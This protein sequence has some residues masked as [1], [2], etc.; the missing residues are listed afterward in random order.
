LS[1][2]NEDLKKTPSKKNKYC[3]KTWRKRRDIK[4]VLGRNWQRKRTY[5]RLA[6][7]TKKKRSMTE[8]Y[9]I[10]TWIEYS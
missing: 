5:Y 2:I 9:K 3:R 4:E 7:S 6:Q 10:T 8:W 1:V